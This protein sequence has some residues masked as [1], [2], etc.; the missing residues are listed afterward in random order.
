[1]RR[2]AAT[3]FGILNYR[4]VNAQWHADRAARRPKI[5][6]L[7]LNAPLREYVQERLSGKIVQSNGQAVKH[8]K[9]TWKGRRAVHRQQRRWAKAWSPE[10]ISQRL[11]IDFPTD[12]TMRISPEAI[13]QSLYIQSRGALRRDLSACLRSGRPLRVPRKRTQKN[14]RSF[15]DP[16]LLIA[17]RPPEIEDRAIPGH[18]EGDLILGLGS[19]AIGTLV[20]RSTRFTLLLYLPRMKSYGKA[21]RVKNGPALAGH[22]TEAVCNA[23]ARTILTLPEEIRKSLTWDQGAELSKHVQLRIATG[24]EI[25]FCDPRSPWQRGT[26]ENTNGLLRQYFPKGTDLSRHSADQIA[27]I[28]Q[29]LNCRPRKTL[30]WKTP[31]EAFAELLRTHE[32]HSV[33]STG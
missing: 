23:I 14:G 25:Y 15:V 20:E 30:K 18:W 4:A 11:R 6:K 8:P 1:L 12:E 28:A 5:P 33:A 16:H 17:N 19:S 3:R 32:N 2:N 27:A 24:L 26:N 31:A 9:V 7:V 29:T 10:Q 13:Y 21:I 22:G